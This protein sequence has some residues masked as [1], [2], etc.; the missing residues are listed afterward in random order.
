MIGDETETRR[1]ARARAGDETVVVVIMYNYCPTP[2]A[3]DLRGAG[4]TWSDFVGEAREIPCTVSDLLISYIFLI[5][6]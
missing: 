2:F 1:R 5:K 6:F 4:V 3:F